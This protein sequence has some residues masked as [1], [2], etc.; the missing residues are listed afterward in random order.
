MA[1]CSLA[2]HI[3]LGVQPARIR[4]DSR[5]H[6]GGTLPTAR[7]T[8]CTAELGMARFLAE[9]AAV[10]R[11]T[12]GRR[13][14]GERLAKIDLPDREIR[15]SHIRVENR[16]EN[17]RRQSVYKAAYSSTDPS[18]QAWLGLDHAVGVFIMEW[19]QL[20][21]LFRALELIRRNPPSSRIELDID[22]ADTD[23]K[24]IEDTL[25]SSLETAGM[26]DGFRQLTKE[27]ALIVHGRRWLGTQE[28][29]ATGLAESGIEAPTTAA[30]PGQKA[31]VSGKALYAA[32]EYSLR[33][34]QKAVSAHV[35]SEAGRWWKRRVALGY[36][37]PKYP[38][39]LD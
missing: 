22:S 14:I 29:P 31:I 10:Q 1:T 4:I 34:L 23:M 30:P 17:G 12:R 26:V 13:G 19:G 39:V 38:S 20:L 33:P 36:R 9:A 18:I 16:V 2:A 3:W 24:R 27:K 28:D 37:R 21:V 8:E 5:E 6:G 35:S 32:V 11:W 15:G 7:I 25:A